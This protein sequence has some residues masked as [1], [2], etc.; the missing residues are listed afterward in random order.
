[1][2]TLSILEK[3]IARNCSSKGLISSLYNMLMSGS[4]DSLNYKLE[5][6]RLD[7]NEDIQI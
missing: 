7:I 4:Q 1:M 2:L 6:W 5:V 3:E